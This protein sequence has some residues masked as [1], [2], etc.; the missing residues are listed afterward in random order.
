MND[1]VHERFIIIQRIVPG[2]AWRFDTI[3]I[4]PM[5]RCRMRSNT[6]V[7]RGITK[8]N[9]YHFCWVRLPT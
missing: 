7:I 2:I 8:I 5:W 1:T 9:A 4:A 6:D 3:P